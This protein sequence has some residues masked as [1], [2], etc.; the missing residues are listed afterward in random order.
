[1]GGITLISYSGITVIPGCGLALLSRNEAENN[2]YPF[3]QG[4][5]QAGA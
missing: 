3:V 1:M 5:A 4:M 2:G